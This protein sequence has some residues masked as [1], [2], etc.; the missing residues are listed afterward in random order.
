MLEEFLMEL[1]L[2]KM[3]F[4]MALATNS[5]T[6]V[7]SGHRAL[8]WWTD[9]TKK[10]AQPRRKAIWVA[11]RTPDGHSGRALVMEKYHVEHVNCQKV[12]RE[13]KDKFRTNYLD[14]INDHQFLVRFCNGVTR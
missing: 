1:N 6:S 2:T 13:V 14:E 3:I 5:R 9:T 12:I 10:A 4:N 7:T 8:H 11:R